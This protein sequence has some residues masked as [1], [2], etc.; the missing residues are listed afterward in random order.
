M[1]SATTMTLPPSTDRGIQFSSTGAAAPT[2]PEKVPVT[3]PLPKRTGE[4]GEMGQQFA[5]DLADKGVNPHVAQLAG[6]GANLVGV[7]FGSVPVPGPEGSVEEWYKAHPKTPAIAAP[8]LWLARGVAP[9]NPEEMAGMAVGGAAIGVAGRGIVR[10]VPAAVGQF[11]TFLRGFAMQVVKENPEFVSQLPWEFQPTVAA[12]MLKDA[13][14]MRAGAA[15]AVP[16]P[17]TPAVAPATAPT[18]VPAVTSTPPPVEV[19][20]PEP[21]PAKGVIPAPTVPTAGEPAPSPATVADEFR[22]M[23]EAPTGATETPTPKGPGLA[24]D[25]TIARGELDQRI[26]P[27]QP[28]PTGYAHTSV[29]GLFKPQDVLPE[30]QA[31][32]D[33]T[34]ADPYHAVKSRPWQHR[35]VLQGWTDTRRVLKDMGFPQVADVGQRLENEQFAQTGE[36]LAAE[37]AA[38]KPVGAMV[39]GSE[40]GRLVDAVG[41]GEVSIADAAKVTPE[42][43]AAADALRV[44]YA[45]LAELQ[46]LPP[47]PHY[48]PRYEELEAAWKPLSA[49]ARTEVLKDMGIALP[50]HLK[51]REL[52]FAVPQVMHDAAAQF[53]LY[54]HLALRY[55]YVE[56]KVRL[57]ETVANNLRS[58]A[59]SSESLLKAIPGDTLKA[60]MERSTQQ[61][62]LRN[63]ARYV[64]NLRDKALGIPQKS[65]IWLGSAFKPVSP[66]VATVMRGNA[67]TRAITPKSWQAAFDRG[68]QWAEDVATG[69]VEDYQAGRALFGTGRTWNSAAWFGFNPVSLLHHNL[70]RAVN[71]ETGL[72]VENM[73]KGVADANAS[74]MSGTPQAGEWAGS[75]MRGAASG[76]QSVTMDEG[77]T[78]GVIAKGSMIGFSVGDNY[79]LR[80]AYFGA[81]HAATVVENGVTKMDP[82][83]FMEILNNSA[84]MSN[85]MS[86]PA[87][88]RTQVGKTAT[89]GAGQIVRMI[90]LKAQGAADVMVG[91]LGTEEAK[92]AVRL[93]ML[94]GVASLM[95]KNSPVRESLMRIMAPLYH[96]AK[97]KLKVGMGAGAITA[98]L[99]A[100]AWYAVQGGVR[101]PAAI[102]KLM[103]ELAL[104]S[105]PVPGLRAALQMHDWLTK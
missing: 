10:A 5:E 101:N 72:G 55:R 62:S 52:E 64:E 63:A 37:R 90:T 38:L 75:W 16:T 85:P 53:E 87:A 15:K 30:E 35:I 102:P 46:G 86:L 27:G 6:M 103:K 60:E 43:R 98:T 36:L 93:A 68:A 104:K 84:L 66:A 100:N 45:K 73:A 91:K 7:P 78:P 61:A 80:V 40:A 65:E 18:E 23:P 1:N 50:P 94:A 21:T 59:D 77:V 83:R 42:I 24:E 99:P 69:K 12:Q 97:G 96:D 14:K 22:Q 25:N 11:P 26:Q 8:A 79:W 47:D 56:P 71:L 76:M 48:W 58:A 81:K 34:F 67:A 3:G 88:L 39:R 74:L 57:L 2:G 95:P 105:L 41:R 92:G 82:A 20:T 32:L 13:A 29:K 49:E 33:A 28:S 4:R 17:E 9:L 31:A 70:G 89:L 54:T 19:P 51:A 44:Q